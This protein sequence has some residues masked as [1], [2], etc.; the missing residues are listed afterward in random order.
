MG[1]VGATGKGRVGKV[2]KLFGRR[3]LKRDA[4]GLGQAVIEAGGTEVGGTEVGGTEM[5]GAEGRGPTQATEPAEPAEPVEQAAPAEPAEPVAGPPRGV[6]AMLREFALWQLS[7]ADPTTGLANQQLVLDRLGQALVRRRRH[8]GEVVVC[9]I[10]LDNLDEFNLEHG[11]ATGATILSEAA[12]QLTSALRAEDT[13]GRLSDR[14]LVAVLAVD[15][16]QVV[17]SLRDRLLQALEQAVPEQSRRLR[18]HADIATVVAG[19]YDSPEEVLARAE[20][21]N[22]VSGQE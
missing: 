21:L 22:R 12:R 17:G 10:V 16:E 19:P 11:Y 8:G 15:D 13:V 14:V 4:P 7:L 1:G 6:E 2:K 18:L 5:G 9:R 3:R 20:R